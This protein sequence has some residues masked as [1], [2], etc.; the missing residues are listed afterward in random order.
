MNLYLD[1]DGVL[2]NFY[3]QMC[4]WHN[5]PYTKIDKWNTEWINENFAQIENNSNFW[6]N[7]EKI[8]DPLELKDLP[9]KGYVTSFPAKMVFA[10][11]INFEN[12]GFPKL[13]IYTVEGYNKLDILQ[14]LNCDL[15]VDDRLD[16][17]KLLNENGIKCLLFSPPYMSYPEEELKGVEVLTFLGDLKLILN[18]KSV[19]V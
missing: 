14:K 8:S 6:S 10:R 2:L 4:L 15:Y 19:T 3:K 17:V 18:E 1:V 13:P 11:K 16:T 12:L 5:K 7:L 9:L